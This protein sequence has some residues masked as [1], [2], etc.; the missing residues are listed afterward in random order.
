MTAFSIP[1]ATMNKAPIMISRTTPS[2]TIDPLRKN[3]IMKIVIPIIMIIH[4]ELHELVVSVVSFNTGQMTLVAAL[5]SAGV[6]VGNG[7]VVTMTGAG[8]GAY[9]SPVILTVGAIVGTAGAGGA[10]G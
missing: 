3:A 5:F 9:L 7:C 1:G 4:I 8:A 10:A 2:T 6:I